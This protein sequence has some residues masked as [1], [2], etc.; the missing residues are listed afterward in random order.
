[1]EFAELTKA[2]NARVQQDLIKKT[3]ATALKGKTI[4]FVGCAAL[5]QMTE[6]AD[7]EIIPVQWS[8]VG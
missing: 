4:S 3:D 1:M 2:F 7:C 5:T 8:E 6:A